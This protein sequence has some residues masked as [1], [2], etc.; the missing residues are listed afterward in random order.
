MFFEPSITGLDIGTVE[1]KLVELAGTG[2]KQLK[3][4][5]VAKLPAGLLEQ[6][7]IKDEAKLLEILRSLFKAQ[8]MRIRGRKVAIALGGSAVIVRMVMLPNKGEVE[9][10]ELIEIEAEQH[11]QHD[12]NDLYLNW[13]VLGSPDGQEMVPVVLVGAKKIV[14]DQYISALKKLGC[15]VR[16]IDCDVFAQM[17]MVEFSA[18][19]L[20]G[21]VVIANI[22]ATATQVTFVLEGRYAYSREI[23]FGSNNYIAAISE[24]MNIP[25]EQASSLLLASRDNP[26]AVSG[27]LLK[28]IS[29]ANEQLA[30]ETQITIDFFFQSV[31]VPPQ[32]VSV[33]HL[34][35]AGSAAYVF[36]LQ[37]TLS[38]R[39]VKT[40]NIIDPFAK[41]IV[42]TRL[43]NSEQVKFPAQY[44]TA[45]GLALREE[46]DTE[47]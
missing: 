38:E 42:P 15:N 8:K 43:R 25:A 7:L 44:G 26:A 39:V 18:G 47:S 33:D 21:L 10:A 1:L 12:I 35:L 40:T 46:G 23:A 5:G 41:L 31:P 27:A 17:N 9:L 22:A 14:V 45:V 36:G 32:I 19:A 29:L 6:G 13:H 20:P 11:F 2:K 30:M 24:A 3:N 34:Y 37:A 16:I 28:A 4:I